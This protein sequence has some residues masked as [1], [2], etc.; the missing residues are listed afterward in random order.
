[1]RGAESL[2]SPALLIDQYRRVAA[3]HAAKFL[4]EMTHRVGR[5]NI[6]RKKD[7]PPRLRVAQKCA[8]IVRE[9]SSG[10]TCD[11][12]GRGHRG[13]LSPRTTQGSS[14]QPLIPLDEAV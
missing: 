1:M 12:C 11:E 10:N 6:A 14:V 4:D 2:H 3:D 13:P 7:E 5:S 9:R 8:L